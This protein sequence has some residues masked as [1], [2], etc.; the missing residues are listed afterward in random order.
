M[1]SS[2]YNFEKSSKLGWDSFFPSTA[3]K[4]AQLWWAKDLPSGRGWSCAGKFVLP[5]PVAH[6]ARCGRNSRNG[7][8]GALGAPVALPPRPNVLAWGR[9]W[10]L[11]E[12]I[13]KNWNDK[14]VPD[15]FGKMKMTKL[16]QVHAKYATTRTRLSRT[17]SEQN[18]WDTFA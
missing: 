9:Q 4:N 13:T 14:K 12:K 15:F 8:V 16:R 5:P 7:P 10:V 1:L 17:R 11:D 3:T 18:W 2:Y 6:A